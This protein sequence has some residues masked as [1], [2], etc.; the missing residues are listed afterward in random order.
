ML[1]KFKEIVHVVLLID[2]EFFMYYFE[3]RVLPLLHS[4][5]KGATVHAISHF[6]ALVNYRFE[7]F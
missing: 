3:S 5:I 1:I 7:H 4:A 2:I 6:L